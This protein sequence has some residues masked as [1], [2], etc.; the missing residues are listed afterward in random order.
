MTHPNTARAIRKLTIA[1][2][3]P[4]LAAESWSRA[5]PGSTQELTEEGRQV[6]IGAHLVEYLDPAAAARRYGLAQ[7]IER[8]RALAIEF[9]VVDVDACREALLRGGV[10]PQ[11]Q[12]EATIV[13]GEDTHG[14]FIS[15]L[16]NRMPSSS[17]ASTWRCANT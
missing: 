9:E 8:G 14:V 17:K 1:V 12:G 10:T 11:H 5:L 6:G 7:R 15:F 3:D 2:P 4:L 13:G 16:P